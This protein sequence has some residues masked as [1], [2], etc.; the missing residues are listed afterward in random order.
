MKFEE[1][2]KETWPDWEM[3][4]Q[5][6]CGANGKVYKVHRK[7]EEIDFYSA[8]KVIS[9][10]EDS[11]EAENLRYEGYD[12]EQTRSYFEEIV[13]NVISEVKLLSSLRGAQNVVRIEDYKVI[14]YPEKQS[15]VIMIR[16]EILTPLNE[17]LCDK[18]LSEEEVIQLGCDLCDAL[19]LCHQN[20]IIHRD[21]KPENIFVNEFGDFKIGDFGISKQMEELSYS[22][23][24]KGTYSYIAPEVIF[25]NHYD[26]SADLYSLGLVLYKILNNNRLPFL[27]ANKQI[28]SATER[29]NATER[30]IKG[31]QLPD[32]PGVSKSLS[33]AIL[34]ACAYDV[35]KRYESAEQFKQ[36]LQGKL[37]SEDMTPS[38]KESQEVDKYEANSPK[39]VTNPMSESTA[40]ENIDSNTNNNHRNKNNAG[41]LV[42]MI[43]A[44]ACV[45]LLFG[46]L[47]I[48]KNMNDKKTPSKEPEPSSSVTETTENSDV[49][50]TV[51]F[52]EMGNQDY[53]FYK[54]QYL[55]LNGEYEEAKSYLDNVIFDIDFFLNHS[56]DYSDNTE[57]MVPDGS[58]RIAN[59]TKH[60]SWYRKNS[61]DSPIQ[62]QIHIKWYWVD[63]DDTADY[64]SVM[65]DYK[66]ADSWYEVGYWL[67]D[68][69][70]NVV[71]SAYPADYKCEQWVYTYINEQLENLKE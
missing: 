48:L 55:L 41:K 38:D 40:K 20:N 53:C 6:G 36:A 26:K 47:M 56:L 5:I 54:A 12:E 58:G 49:Q 18:K 32:I 39:E 25:G 65:L 62:E 34:K 1:L 43:A 10:P 17:F 66:T 59:L 50:E 28:L 63:E 2:L 3:D 60:Y 69:D 64:V 61:I 9:I 33:D 31:E 35:T 27:D 14:E 23:S 42:M 13:N 19:S 22:M 57:E 70:L 52:D 7:D 8:V 21:I 67:L 51:Y 68:R 46:I 15:W 44:I 16:M 37:G 45:C 4:C 29:R 71:I 30:R 11:S 24:Q